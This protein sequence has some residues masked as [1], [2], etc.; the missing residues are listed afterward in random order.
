MVVDLRSIVGADG[1]M[2]I[3]DV[4]ARTGS[5]SVS[6]WVREGRLLKL[7][8]HVVVLPE[9]AGRWRTRAV[10]AALST[11][12]VL[13][14]ASALALWDLAEP[15]GRVHVA[16]DA[17]RRAPEPVDWL[18]VHRVTGL[19][20]RTRRG[21]PVTAPARSVVDAWGAAHQDGG[22]AAAVR[23]VRAAAISAV[24]TGRSDVPEL[25][26][27]LTRRPQLPGRGLLFELVS[28]VAA[29]A[30]SELEIWGVLHVL[31]VPGLPP[32]RQ[33]HRVQLPGTH[34]D[35]DVAWPEVRLAV[36]LDGAAFHGS[37]EQRERDLRRDAALAALGWLVLRF[38]YRRLTR[39][40]AAC[41]AEIAAV[42]R[43][44][45]ALAATHGVR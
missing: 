32:Y 20:P 19:S 12:G 29:G 18:D 34:A 24:R 5:T 2:R 28:L 8:P 15:D 1:A 30:Q 4:A 27:E 35:L 9:D 36:E 16:I 39:E 3:S 41:R 23:E 45:L 31:D 44:R 37:A 26:R 33:Q 13:S 22:S 7:L 6:R 40:P 10:A 11:R 21:L 43:T 38:S 42:Y 14:H 17:R 25:R